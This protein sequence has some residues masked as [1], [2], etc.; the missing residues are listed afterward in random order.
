MCI[1]MDEERED[2][3]RRLLE[4]TGENTK[5]G[6]IDVAIKH[7]LSDLQNKER[8]A[9]DPPDRRPRGTAYALHPARTGDDSRPRR[10][11]EGS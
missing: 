9:D 8:V 2:R 7:Y 11:L 1:R 4:A 10:G 3:L 6:A 5:S